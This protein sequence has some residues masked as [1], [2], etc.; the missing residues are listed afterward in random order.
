LGF[1]LVSLSQLFIRNTANE[2]R[3]ISFRQATRREAEILFAA[4]KD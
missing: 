3:I 1:S 4:I 2:I